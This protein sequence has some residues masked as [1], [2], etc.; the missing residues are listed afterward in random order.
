MYLSMVFRYSKKWWYI[1]SKANFKFNKKKC[2]QFH[3]FSFESISIHFRKMVIFFVVHLVGF[4]LCVCFVALW[5]KWNSVKWIFVLCEI[6]ICFY[7]C[8]RLEF[9]GFKFEIPFMKGQKLDD[10]AVCTLV[11]ICLWRWC[12]DVS[13]T[14]FC[15]VIVCLFQAPQLM[16]LDN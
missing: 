15:N 3:L 5:L 8:I 14:H 4:Q 2:F 7:W 12:D 16:R 6:T 10:K 1:F 11:C 13:E 9:E